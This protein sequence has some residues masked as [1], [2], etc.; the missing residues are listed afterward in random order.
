MF[1]HLLDSTIDE[2]LLTSSLPSK[3]VSFLREAFTEQ[4]IN[5]PVVASADFKDTKNKLYELN[6][7]QKYSIIAIDVNNFSYVIIP[8][9]QFSIH[10]NMLQQVFSSV[11]FRM[12]ES[13]IS[14]HDLDPYVVELHRIKAQLKN[15]FTELTMSSRIAVLSQK[16]DNEHFTFP[17]NTVLKVYYECGRKTKYATMDEAQRDLLSVNTIYSCKHCNNYHQ[18]HEPSQQVI[19]QHVM[20]ERWKVSWRRYQH[21]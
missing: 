21:I 10:R 17:D 6:D 15:V 19:P 4:N 5:S 9:Y 16:V 13:G 1:S 7:G 11:I 14:G 12:R 18:G 3:F 8:D 20:E 2:I